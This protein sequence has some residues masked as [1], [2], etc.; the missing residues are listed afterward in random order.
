MSVHCDIEPASPVPS[1][2]SPP[3][4]SPSPPP[5]QSAGMQVDELGDINTEQEKK[6]GEL[7]KEK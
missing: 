1:V 6:L 5:S 2:L 3:L 4:L 7:V